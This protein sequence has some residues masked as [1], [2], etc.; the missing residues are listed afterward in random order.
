MYTSAHHRYVRILAPEHGRCSGA[1]AA[2]RKERS[3][4]TASLSCVSK[5][6]Q[7]GVA[8]SPLVRWRF[9]HAQRGEE[10]TVVAEAAALAAPLESADPPAGPTKASVLPDSMMTPR[11]QRIGFL[12]LRCCFLPAAVS[13]LQGAVTVREMVH[14]EQDRAVVSCDIIMQFGSTTLW[15]GRARRILPPLMFT[16]RDEEDSRDR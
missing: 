4:T 8:M 16:W 15:R 2:K 14:V 6:G 10:R 12:I 7:T 5:N 1:K 13:V 3:K 11:S 9:W